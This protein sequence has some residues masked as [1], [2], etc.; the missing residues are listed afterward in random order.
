MR[1]GMLAT[2]RRVTSQPLSFRRS[3]TI[4]FSRP[5][6]I[7]PPTIGEATS[8]IASLESLA[9]LVLQSRMI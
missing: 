9:N 2:G 4:R 5:E 8:K 3:L 7:Q 1:L 6:E